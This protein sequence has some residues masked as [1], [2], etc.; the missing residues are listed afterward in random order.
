MKQWHHVV[1][2]LESTHLNVL[3]AQLQHLTESCARE[4]NIYTSQC[5][6]HQVLWNFTDQRHTQTFIQI[7]QHL[8]TKQLFNFAQLDI[9]K[10]NLQKFY[11]NQVAKCHAFVLNDVNQ[12]HYLQFLLSF[13]LLRI[14]FALVL[15]CTW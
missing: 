9:T 8:Q 11:G 14:F 2:C 5:S 7:Y 4:V 3:N 1:S 12:S 10:I 13:F 15:F 6:K